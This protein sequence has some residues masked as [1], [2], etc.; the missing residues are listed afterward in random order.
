MQVI[1]WDVDVR[2]LEGVALVNVTSVWFDSVAVR[3]EFFKCSKGV[4][5]SDVTKEF[6][7]H[8]SY[9]FVGFKVV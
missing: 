6:S 2:K 5:F 4:H 7:G 3:F 9:F 8:E 1:C